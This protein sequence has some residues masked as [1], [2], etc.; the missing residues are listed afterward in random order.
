MVEKLIIGKAVDGLLH[1]PNQ[2]YLDPINVR[3]Q[4]NRSSMIIF[5]AKKTN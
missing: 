4:N 1:G 3:G 5:N 2:I